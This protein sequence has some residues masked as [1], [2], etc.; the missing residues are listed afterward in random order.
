MTQVSSTPIKNE[1]EH[2]RGVAIGLKA[3]DAVENVRMNGRELTRM[4]A[5]SGTTFV[6]I[7]SGCTV[8][9]VIAPLA[10]HS[11]RIARAVFR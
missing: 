8:V 1:A 3:Q 2:L 7:Y 9:Y 11:E 5:P 10:T 6:S 4:E